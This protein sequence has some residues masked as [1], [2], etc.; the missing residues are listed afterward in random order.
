M[1]FHHFSNAQ[2]VTLLQRLRGFVLKS[3]LINDLRRS[4]L[5]SLA[6]RLLLVGAAAEVRHDALL[7]IRRGFR[8]GELSALLRQLDNVTVS[9][10]PARWFRIA[11]IIRFKPG[12]NS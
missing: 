5:A 1:C 10:E 3:V 2:I 9:V 11:A 12:A 6:A 7:S 4:R 8:I